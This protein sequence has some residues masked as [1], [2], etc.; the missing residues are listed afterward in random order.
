MRK[1]WIYVLTYLFKHTL[2]HFDVWNLG[3]VFML[4]ETLVTA[5]F[6]RTFRLIGRMSYAQS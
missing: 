6:C 5:T 2:T 4:C 1:Q 3:I